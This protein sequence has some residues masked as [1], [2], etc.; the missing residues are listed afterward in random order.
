MKRFFTRRLLLL[1]LLAPLF[2]L[3]ALADDPVEVNGIYYTLVP[4]GKIATVTQNPNGYSGSID[5]PSSITVTSSGITYSVVGIEDNAFHSCFYLT[6][7]SIPNSVTSIGEC[8]VHLRSSQ[9]RLDL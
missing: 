1:A 4:K 3:T 5:I 6:S 9:H 2:T 7:V 8:E